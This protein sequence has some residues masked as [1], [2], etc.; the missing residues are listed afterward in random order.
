MK[1][2]K[3]VYIALSA[4]LMFSCE[5]FLDEPN[6]NAPDLV[7]AVNNLNDTDKV[8]N[9]VYNSLFNHFVVSV[10]ED[11]YRSDE[12]SVLNRLNPSSARLEQFQYLS[13]T[14]NEGTRFI[15]QRWGA[16]YR[17]IFFA[18]QTLF[19]LDKIRPSLITDADIQTWNEQRAQALFFRGLYHF[20][21]HSVFNEGNVIIRDVYEPDV[22][23]RSKDVSSSEEVRAFFRKDIEEALEFLPM[24]SE[25][26]E[27]R[28]SIG[29]ATM[30]LAN[31]YLYEGT[32]EAMSK[33]TELYESLRDDFGYTLETDVTKMFTT[34]G[35]FNSESIFEIPYT[36]AFNLELDE[37]DERS[38]QNR[39]A[40][41]TSHFTFQGQNFLQPSTWLIMAYEQEPIDAS[42][43]VNTIEVG[44]GSIDTRRVSLR[45]SSMVMLNN[46]L[47][48]PVYD[49]PNALQ[50]GGLRGNALIVS[51]F[52]KYTNHDLGVANEN[53]TSTSDRLKSGKNVTVNR[54]SEVLLNLAECYIKQGRLDDAITEINKIRSRW[55]LELLDI[56]SQIDN[57]ALPYDQTSL[58]NRLM[59]FEKP[60]ELSV[61]G[62]A[63]R[64]IDLRR[65]GIAEQRYSDLSD[66]VYQGVFFPKPGTRNITPA[67]ARGPITSLTNP[68]DI[69]V[70]DGVVPTDPTEVTRM[71]IFTEFSEA[72]ANYSI[73]NGYLPIPAEEVLNNDSL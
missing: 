14:Y 37:F 69:V 8:L 13:Q 15:G 5:E 43:P 7:D 72:S 73:N 39:L 66:V 63:T 59:F 47:D 65:W 1:K 20:Y 4:L 54:L 2:I 46:D 41:R 28:I 19:A 24:P 52:K 30:I 61:E 3:F 6:P 55:A 42:N 62:H 10:E 18:N 40:A 38:P 67:L 53:S 56:N 25:T 12:G 60:L 68:S 58:M 71:R 35:E 27:G 33:A 21:A 17:G 48:T 16:L 26:E 9:S 50:R 70:F 29:A 34:A 11:G 23:K 64:V 36:T 57:N 51:V 32:P 22:T 31:S 45:A 49:Q 44:D